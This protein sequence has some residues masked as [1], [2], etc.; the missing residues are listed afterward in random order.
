MIYLPS[1]PMDL[2][3]IP[4]SIWR[5]SRSKRKEEGKEKS[6]RKERERG[7]EEKFNSKFPVNNSGW[8]D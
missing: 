6:K 2:D 7:T 3:S 8:N 1:V 5:R 4:I